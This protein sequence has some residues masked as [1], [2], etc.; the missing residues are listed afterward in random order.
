MDP[1]RLVRRKSTLSLALCVGALT[2]FGATACGGAPEVPTEEEEEAPADFRPDRTTLRRVNIDTSAMLSPAMK[3]AMDNAPGKIVYSAPYDGEPVSKKKT[4]E[5]LLIEDF[6]V[7]EGRSVEDDTLVK[8]HYQGFLTN[9]FKFDDSYAR[10]TPIEIQ[11]GRPGMIA[12]FDKGIRG[13]RPGGKRRIE[14]PGSLAYGPTGR[15][16]IPPDATLVFLLEAIAVEE[17]P[18]PPAGKEAF[19]GSPTKTDELAGGL[20]VQVFA[21][22][23]GREAKTGDMVKVHYTGYLANGDKFDSS[24]DRNAPFTVPLGAGRV[25]KGWDQ[26]LLG[27]KKGDLRKLIIPPELAYGPGGRGKI[28]PNATLTFDIEVLDVMEAPK[29]VAAPPRGG[30]PAGAQPARQP[31]SR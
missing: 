9:G 23:E 2:V 13:M 29:P 24:V 28:P 3:A 19:S 22:G 10:G 27:A 18:P 17:P 12:G 4:A 30:R 14:I 7:G 1:A 20:E 11:V 6:V 16:P 8:L 15:G 26:G 25:I 31:T 5:G 21:T